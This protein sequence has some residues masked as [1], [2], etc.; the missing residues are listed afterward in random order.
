MSWIDAFYN[1]IMIL[2][3]MGPVDD[4]PTSGAKIFAGLYA[5]FSGVIFLSTV[6]I[7]FAPLVHRL[8][9]LMHIEESA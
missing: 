3:G 6:G 8:L 5:M 1:A 4:M 9:H 2:T 7:M